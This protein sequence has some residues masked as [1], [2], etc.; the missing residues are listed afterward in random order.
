MLCRL[1]PRNCNTDRSENTA[2]G[3]C[4]QPLDP[5]ISRAGLHHWEEPVIS[6]T[7]GSGAVFFTGC[8]LKCVFCQ[9]Y[10][11]S[12]KNRGIAVTV[13]RLK[14]IYRE[15]IS[16]GAHNINLVTPGH[17]LE[18]VKASLTEKLPVPVVY[19]TNSYE[20]VDSLS[21]LEGKIDIYLP[22]L[23]YLDPTLSRDLS[24]AQDYPQVAKAAIAEMYR[25]T[26]PVVLGNDG[27]LKRGVIIRHLALPGEMQNTLDVIDYVSKTYPGEQ[28][29]FS[30]MFQ[31]LPCGEVE[32]LPERYAALRR[33]LVFKELKQ[34]RDALF[35]SKIEYGFIQSYSSAKAEFIPSFDGSG[36]L[37]QDT[38]I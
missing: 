27:L 33:K 30:L 17:Y 22:D 15:L 2:S 5:V 7:N 14:A 29:M 25:Q 12:T 1:C 10:D 19:N 20:K 11:I 24:R 37:E 23:K 16:Q 9:N 35:D 21:C 13:E 26:G 28:V 4:G 3:F 31:Y 8:N 32:S 6:G 36:V 34:L 38:I 18:A